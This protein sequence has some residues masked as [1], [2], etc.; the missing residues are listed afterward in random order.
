MTNG[1]FAITIVIIITIIITIIYLI[2]SLKAPVV[3]RKLITPKFTIN[4]DYLKAF[5]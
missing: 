4:D 5:K 3:N 1:Q 2:F